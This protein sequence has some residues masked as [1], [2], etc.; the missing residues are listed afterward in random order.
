MQ[1]II[2]NVLTNRVSNIIKRHI[3]LM[4]FAAYMAFWF[5]KLFHFLVHFLNYYISVFMFLRFCLI[6]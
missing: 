3:D 1:S 6:S 5:R 2:V 4:K